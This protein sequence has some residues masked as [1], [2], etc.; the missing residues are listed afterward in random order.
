M[1]NMPE[2]KHSSSLI[3]PTK[4]TLFHIDFDWWQANDSNWRI[5]LFEFLCDEHQAYFKDKS[6]TIKI[7]SI[8]PETAE[9]KQEDGLLYELM[10]HCAKREDFINPNIP[11]IAKVLR[12]FLANGNQPLSAGV[13]AEIVN[14][15]VTTVLATLSGSQVYKG[16]RQ[17]Q[18]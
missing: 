8:D 17:Y 4:D 10:H 7:D 12:T 13:L 3:K 1:I 5:F 11:I 9:I 2:V 14:R 6:D 18:K 15:P 16:I